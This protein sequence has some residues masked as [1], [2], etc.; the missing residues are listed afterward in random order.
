MWGLISKKGRLYKG[1]KIKI[2]IYVS[3]IQSTRDN[4]VIC[5]DSLRIET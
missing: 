1:F 4:I 2:Q 5:S 3:E